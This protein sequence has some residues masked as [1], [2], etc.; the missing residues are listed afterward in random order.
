ML[1][2][3][4]CLCL[5]TSLLLLTAVRGTFAKTLFF[6]DF[7]GNKLDTTKWEI[8]KW[9]GA[10]DV[11]VEKGKVFLTSGGSARAGILTI[12]KFNA[13]KEKIVVTALGVEPGPE[14]QQDL[15]FGNG[16][17]WE[18]QIEFVVRA[19]GATDFWIIRQGGAPVNPFKGAGFKKDVQCVKEGQKF[20]FITDGKV[21]TEQVVDEP[22]FKGDFRVILYLFPAGTSSWDSL[23]VEGPGPEAVD[24]REKLATSW[25]AIKA[26][27]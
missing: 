18:N 11:K 3:A 8:V 15:Y 9:V 13:D 25:G 1:R 16:K 6:D 2:Q 19:G 12:P 24:S 20:T 27:Y 17:A 10:V 7:D 14:A 21:Q 23:R 5:F 26:T 22:I 4:L